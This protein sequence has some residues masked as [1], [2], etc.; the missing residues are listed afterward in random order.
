VLDLVWI[1]VCRWATVESGADVLAQLL[2]LCGAEVAQWYFQVANQW[3][4]PA[5][6]SS[7][8]VMGLTGEGAKP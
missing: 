3:E 6:K 8:M 4:F 7:I 5:C 1:P 2:Q